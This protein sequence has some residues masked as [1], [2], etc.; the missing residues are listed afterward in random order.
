MNSLPDN[1][2]IVNLLTEQ[3]D[4]NEIELDFL[5]YCMTLCKIQIY[6]FEQMFNG[7][8]LIGLVAHS[9]GH[10]F[11]GNENELLEIANLVKDL[12]PILHKL[13]SEIEHRQIDDN[14][15]NNFFRNSLIFYANK[16]NIDLTGSELL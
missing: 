11:K 8:N 4:I 16:N 5:I 7:N 3:Y 9:D 1:K 10:E 6:I 13:R 15:F 2:I 14:T 12:N